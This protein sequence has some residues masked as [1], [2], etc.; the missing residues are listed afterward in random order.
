MSSLTTALLRKP[1]L[2]IV[3]L[4]LARHAPAQPS[5][6][7]TNHGLLTYY[8]FQ[9]AAKKREETD[10]NFVKRKGAWAMQKATT[11][12]AG[13]GKAKTGSWKLRLYQWGEKIVD[14]IEFEELA[15]KSLDP[16]LGP[17]ILHP[18][19]SG[20]RVSEKAEA[21]DTIPLYYPPSILSP[22]S[23][24]EH[25]DVLLRHRTPRHRRGFWFWFS[26]APFTAPFALLPIIP[27]IPFFFCVW[28]AWHHHRAH[29]ASQY[30]EECVKRKMIEPEASEEL[31]KLYKQSSTDKGVILDR[32]RA[33]QISNL[34]EIDE[35]D[36]LRA[37]EQANA[38]KTS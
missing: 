27:N 32:E 28:R 16:S 5:N 21:V 6:E 13:F 10:G 23:C 12:W 1:A 3:A 11:T 17:S 31:D 37:V 7:P 33:L 29:R 14:R 2:R 19:I 38:R 25:L 20:K 18:D 35:V 9:S 30:L 36:I 8:H 26:I 15:L 24:L 22:S 4:P 34:M